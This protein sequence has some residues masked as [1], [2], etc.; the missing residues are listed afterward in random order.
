MKFSFPEQSRAEQMTV[1]L[2]Q[3]GLAHDLRHD[4]TET[5]NRLERD[6]YRSWAIG[7]EIKDAVPDFRE[8]WIVEI[9]AGQ[10]FDYATEARLRHAAFQLGCYV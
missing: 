3:M 4:E 6:D 9:A 5:F 8:A 7:Q 2:E 10:Q 1:L